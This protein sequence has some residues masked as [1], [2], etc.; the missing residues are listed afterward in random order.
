VELWL[1]SRRACEAGGRLIGEK[2]EKDHGCETLRHIRL[3][4]RDT[5]PRALVL[6]GRVARS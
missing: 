5:V 6:R 2:L 4:G 3:P 1:A